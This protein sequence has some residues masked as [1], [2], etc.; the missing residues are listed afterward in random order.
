MPVGPVILP[1]RDLPPAR[2][3]ERRVIVVE[4]D[5]TVV[6]SSRRVPGPLVERNVTTGPA[7]GTASRPRGWLHSAPP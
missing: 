7:D 1:V 2:P 4:A 6:A 5:D 3:V